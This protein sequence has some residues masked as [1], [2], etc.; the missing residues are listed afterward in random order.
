MCGYP[1]DD[2]SV[3]D[4][5]MYSGMAIYGVSIYGPNMAL[6]LMTSGI[7]DGQQCDVK[8]GQAMDIEV[9]RTDPVTD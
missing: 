8:T 2:V 5:Q 4:L 9:F 3:L 6:I 1:G 7:C